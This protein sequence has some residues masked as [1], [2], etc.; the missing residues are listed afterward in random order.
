MLCAKLCARNKD[1]TVDMAD[2]VSELTEHHLAVAPDREPGYFS[3]LWQVQKGAIGGAG[4]E[5]GEYAET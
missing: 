3:V 5:R 4:K 2:M 1:L